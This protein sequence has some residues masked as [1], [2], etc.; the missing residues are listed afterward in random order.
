LPQEF[1][2]RTHHLQHCLFLVFLFSSVVVVVVVVTFVVVFLIVAVIFLIAVVAVTVVCFFDLVFG[3]WTSV[4]I[5]EAIEG[6]QN[7]QK[8]ARGRVPSRIRA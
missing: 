7:G 1:L 6:K 2:H 4:H 3:H 5:M 8:A